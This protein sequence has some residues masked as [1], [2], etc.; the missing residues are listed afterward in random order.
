MV[1]K[2]ELFGFGGL[3]DSIYYVCNLFGNLPRTSPHGVCSSGLLLCF[4]LT[5]VKPNLFLPPDR[6][7]CP[8]SLEEI[9]FHL[10]RPRP[11][12]SQRITGDKMGLHRCFFRSSSLVIPFSLITRTTGEDHGLDD[13]SLM[14]FANIFSISSSAFSFKCKVRRLG[15]RW[16]CFASPELCWCC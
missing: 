11:D 5:I 1:Y 15:A 4:A 3:L 6:G 9:C 7:I 8:R 16:V 14:P 10:D 12:S 2:L 13:G